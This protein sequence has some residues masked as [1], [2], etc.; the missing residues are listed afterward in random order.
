MWQSGRM[1]V[2]T[3]N[4][5]C[6]LIQQQKDPVGLKGS[7]WKR[8]DK[9]VFSHVILKVTSP[10]HR[11]WAGSQKLDDPRNSMQSR[12]RYSRPLCNL[13]VFLISDCA[14]QQ[15]YPKAENCQQK[16]CYNFCTIISHL[17]FTQGV[18]REEIW[19]FPSAT[20]VPRRFELNKCFHRSAS[21][22]CFLAA[23]TWH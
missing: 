10:S 20:G 9:K 16:N 15:K 8:K 7:N 3:L 5:S 22:F 13:C 1:L 2:W 11:A 17:I 18:C 21:D 19:W 14:T 23:T 6:F 12:N 4:C